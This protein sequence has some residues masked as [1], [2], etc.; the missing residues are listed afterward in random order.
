MTTASTSQDVIFD[1][2][3]T[4]WQINWL[5]TL[6]SKSKCLNDTKSHQRP[7]IMA[8]QPGWRTYINLSRSRFPWSC[9]NVSGLNIDRTSVQMNYSVNSFIQFESLS[10]FT[11]TFTLKPNCFCCIDIPPGTKWFKYFV[12]AKCFEIDRRLS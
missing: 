5:S 11:I 9:S 8:I 10:Y 12:L 1:G 7:H 6:L 3:M 4:C 2:L